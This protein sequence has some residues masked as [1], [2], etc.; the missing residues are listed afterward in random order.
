MIR[1]PPRSTLFPY[2]T[3]FRSSD[4]GDF[5]PGTQAAA[6]F[7]VRAPLKEVGLTKAEIRQL[8]AELG[9][10]TADKPQMACLSSRIPYG[11]PVTEEKLL[12]IEQAE[13]VLR[14]LGFYDVRVRHHELGG[15]TVENRMTTNDGQTQ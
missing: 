9:L 4:V 7:Q 1:R 5:R 10:P 13:N 3:L 8:S 15:S 12:M 14:D 2:T 11:E 6:E